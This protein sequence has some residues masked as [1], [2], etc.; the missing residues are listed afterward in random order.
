MVTMIVVD[1]TSSQVG[2]FTSFISTRTSCRKDRSLRGYCAIFPTGSISENP[3]TLWLCSSLFIF[4]ASAISAAA[5]NLP[6]APSHL[7]ARPLPVGELAGEEGFEPPLS[8][9]ETDGLPLNL[10]P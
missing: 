4:A 1:L 2:Q 6:Q 7:L 5:F 10:L 9:L 3:L 8:V